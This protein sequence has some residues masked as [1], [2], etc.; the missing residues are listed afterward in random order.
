MLGPQVLPATG[1]PAE[2]P[3]L[4]SMMMAYE[5]RLIAETLTPTGG[6]ATQEMKHLRVSRKTLYDKV[7]KDKLVANDFARKAEAGGRRQ[8]AGITG[9]G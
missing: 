5:A 9:R 8:E 2:M 6:N 4:A 7:N 3:G 1:E